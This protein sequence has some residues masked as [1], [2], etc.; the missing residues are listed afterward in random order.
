MRKYNNPGVKLPRLGYPLSLWLFL[1]LTIT[2]CGVSINK[3]NPALK[4]DPDV[5]PA[6]VYFIRPVPV[7][8]KG[9][10]DNKIVVNYDGRR[11]LS[12]AE[13]NYTM[14]ELNPSK[15]EITTHSKTMFTNR[16]VPLNVSRS[17]VFTFVPGGTYFI[18]LK[19]DNQEFRGIFYDPE[20]V[21]LA[22]AKSLADGLHASGSLARH[23]PI[24][25]IQS[26]APVPPSGPLE[27]VTPEQLYRSKSP[28]LLK[29]PIKK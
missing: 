15:G 6:K 14:V 5:V 12:I 10:A 18:H 19:R 21:D 17:R 8:H 16:I 24:D 2:G 25:E 23:E 27:P 28:Y 11:L 4:L 29:T 1:T 7:K 20:P 3:N 26:I 22:T 9:I 13:G